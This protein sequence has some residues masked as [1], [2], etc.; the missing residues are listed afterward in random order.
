MV[1]SAVVLTLAFAIYLAFQYATVQRELLNHASSQADIIGANVALM[2]VSEDRRMVESTLSALR[3]VPN[4]LAACI[5]LPSGQVFAS[6]G[7]PDSASCPEVRPVGDD[8][9]EN[10]LLLVRQLRVKDQIVGTL[11]IRASSRA[12]DWRLIQFYTTSSAVFVVCL[13]TA[14]VVSR[15]IQRRVSGPLIELAELAGRITSQKDYTVRAHKRDNDEVGVLIDAF[16][17]MLAQIETRTGDLL[18]LN[19]QLVA[20]KEKAEGATRLKSQFLANMSH[21]IRTPMNGI[22][23]MTE[24]VM[25]TPLTEEQRDY[26]G[27]AK[28]SAESL[29]AIVNDI[30]DFSKI[31]AGRMPLDHTPFAPRQLVDDTMRTLQFRA[32]Q[33]GLAFHCFLAPDVPEAVVG[34]PT[35]LR[36]VLVNLV[37]NAIK[38]TEKGHV[39]IRVT[40]VPASVN[41]ATAPSQEPALPSP[42]D[43]TS[44][45]IEQPIAEDVTLSF[46]V[47]DTGIGITEN[48]QQLVFEA[49]AQADGSVTRRFGG[50]GLGLSISSELIRLMGGRISVRSAPGK[51]STFSFQV[52]LNCTL[53]QTVAPSEAPAAPPSA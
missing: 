29:L 12:V 14:F 9:D 17:E 51:G 26:I 42:G 13:L 32:R 53:H 10:G 47:E 21:E 30:L 20:A 33:K 7:G 15:G 27:C 34:D 35:R 18:R 23:G 38:F 3:T 11:T 22:L 48:C 39:R 16:N 49:F 6:Y 4:V 24:L 43:D 1:T 28:M 19:H 36:Q 8:R 52:P 5:R 25:C 37:G 45:A 2:L 50:T 41:T 46:E 44:R 31:E 40:V